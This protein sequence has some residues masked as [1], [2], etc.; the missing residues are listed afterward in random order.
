MKDYILSV[1]LDTGE[2]IE[3]LTSYEEDDVDA[4]AEKVARSFTN[5]LVRFAGGIIVNTSH[6][7]KIAVM[8]A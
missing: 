1:T 5:S 8:E 7:V 4:V 6:I 2:K 3:V